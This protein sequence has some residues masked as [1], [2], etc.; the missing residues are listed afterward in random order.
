MPT[1]AT[2]KYK[3]ASQA[4]EIQPVE[5]CNQY[6]TVFSDMEVIAFRRLSLKALMEEC[7]NLGPVDSMGQWGY[8]NAYIY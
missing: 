3:R 6:A 8:V 7:P 2:K 1:A 5:A 4:C